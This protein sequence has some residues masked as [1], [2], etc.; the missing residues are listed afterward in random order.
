MRLARLRRARLAWPLGTMLVMLGIANLAHAQVGVNTTPVGGRYR[1]GPSVG[2]GYGGYRGYFPG[3]R[4]CAP[5]FGR[6]CGPGW[7]WNRFC[8]RPCY[9]PFTFYSGFYSPSIYIGTTGY[10]GAYGSSYGT[11]YL[12]ALVE[13][14]NLLRQQLAAMQGQNQPANANQAAK[15]VLPQRRKNPA[16]IA[17][18][19]QQAFRDRSGTYVTSGIRL[20]KAG[21]YNRAAERFE[22]AA[23]LAADDAT[24]HFLRTQS[25]IATKRY[26][27]AAVAL[28]NG[29]KLNGDW[30]DLGFDMRGLYDDQADLASQMADLAAELQ[31]NPLDRDALLLLGF[32]LFMTGRKEE[33]RPLLEQVVRLEPDDSHVKPFFDHFEKLAND[34]KP[35]AA[36]E[37]EDDQAQRKDVADPPAARFAVGQV[38]DAK[39][40]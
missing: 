30:L 39:G 14:N 35:V 26:R 27:D 21:V 40:Q 22:E 32:E 2:A 19:K 12:Q 11:G 29:L 4:V 9:Y 6:R 37:Q 18:A 23:R 38:D 5:G 28:K 34:L 17:Q 1:C 16:Q 20:F 15:V 10:G 31:A 8:Y 24:P 13:Q 25:L 33:A 3:R 7:G 36:E